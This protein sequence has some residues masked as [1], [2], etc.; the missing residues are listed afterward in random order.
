MLRLSPTVLMLFDKFNEFPF[1]LVITDL[2]MPELSGWGVIKRVKEKNSSIPVILITGSHRR[3]S[4]K[5][6]T[7]FGVDFIIN[8]PFNPQKLLDMVN[9]LIR[10]QGVI[11]YPPLERIG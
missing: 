4:E 6:L 3:Y 9:E 2:K 10:F 5:N 11:P 1:D 7:D 8:K